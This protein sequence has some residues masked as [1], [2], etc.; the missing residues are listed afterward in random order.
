MRAYLL[1]R[2]S[3]ILTSGSSFLTTVNKTSLSYPG[4]VSLT[5]WHWY[6]N[7]FH[8]SLSTVRFE[9]N[10]G[11]RTYQCNINCSVLRASNAIEKSYTNI[12][13]DLSIA[14][15]IGTF[16]GADQDGSDPSGHVVILA[17]R[18]MIHYGVCVRALAL[19]TWT[20]TFHFSPQ[21]CP[22]SPDIDFSY[23]CC[24]YFDY[25]ERVH[26]TTT[27]PTDSA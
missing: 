2:S 10:D 3:R 11:L 26:L 20:L 17:V 24:I 9:V 13:K 21:F 12:R 7:I 1:Q 4:L 6:G 5:P 22:C 8:L 19:L 25:F 23:G 18:E 14:E 27:S 15:C 16:V